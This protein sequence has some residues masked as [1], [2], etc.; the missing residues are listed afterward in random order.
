MAD[1]PVAAHSPTSPSNDTIVTSKSR[2]SLDPKVVALI[3]VGVLVCAF[4][5]Y[6][7]L[8][9]LPF[10][11]TSNQVIATV[12]PEKIYQ[13]DLDTE[14]G[15]F[16]QYTNLDQRSFLLSKIATDSAILQ[17]AAEAGFV[18]LNS[19]TFNSPGKD[20]QARLELVKEIQKKIEENSNHIEGGI[21]SIFFINNLDNRPGPLGYAKSQQ[22]AFNTISDLQKRVKGKEL[23]IEAAGEAVRNN[24]ALAQIDYS[25]AVNSYFKF[26]LNKGE[27]ITIDQSIDDTLW[28]LS[29]SEVSEVLPGKIKDADGNIREGVYMFG[30][31]TKKN[32]T[33]NIPG[34]RQWRDDQV[35]KYA[36]TNY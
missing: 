7:F 22:L 36:L 15:Y 4:A 20:Y 23:T 33:S 13:T 32:S 34:F 19:S 9:K 30:V 25:Y 1:S 24:Q 29:E 16:P 12:G 35:K 8:G 17:G 27:R 5:V 11:S 14:L 10:S 2:F 6:A 26:D 31:I 21:V 18:T 28:S 3:I